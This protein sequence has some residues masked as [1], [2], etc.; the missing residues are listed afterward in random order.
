MLTFLHVAAPRDMELH[1]AFAN[2]L[3][4]LT[5]EKGG[6]KWRAVLKDPAQV[7]IP[8]C[9]HLLLFMVTPRPLL[10]TPRPLLVTPRPLL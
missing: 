5:T 7:C 1:T 6:G 2:A 9:A 4:Q 10:V 3:K 8:L